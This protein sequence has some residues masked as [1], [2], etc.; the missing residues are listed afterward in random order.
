MNA[1]KVQHLA[2][3]LGE[4]QD[5]YFFWP[6]FAL[7]P[8]IDRD[9]VEFIPPGAFEVRMQPQGPHHDEGDVFPN[10][11]TDESV[12]PR[13]VCHR[14]LIE[15]YRRRCDTIIAE[16]RDEGISD[17]ADPPEGMFT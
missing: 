6:K 5:I 8:S 10:G 17:F 12:D 2:A 11:G 13:R 3:L 9:G 4:L 16:L 1:E 15:A 7:K 14:A